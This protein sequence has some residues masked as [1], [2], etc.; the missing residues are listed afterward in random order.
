MKVQIIV[1]DAIETTQNPA[2]G[3]VNNVINPSLVFGL[4]VVPSAL[5]FSASVLV[6]GIDNGIGHKLDFKIT[7]SKGT[8][9]G[10]IS[11]EMPVQSS[12]PIDM[13]NF[14][15]NFRNVL[16]EDEG[17]YKVVFCVDGQIEGEQEFEVKDIRNQSN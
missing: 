4:P 15:L 16:F 9:I 1:A 6:K 14:N 11:G 2:G 10:N 17:I 7:N 8:E 12:S 5:S 13:S 3:G